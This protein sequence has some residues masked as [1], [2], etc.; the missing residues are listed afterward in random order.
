MNLFKRLSAL[1]T[2]TALFCT[3]SVSAFT[4]YAADDEEDDNIRV[5]NVFY[6]NDVHNAYEQTDSA[7]GYASL[8]ADI[9]LTEAEE[10]NDTVLVDAGDA[11]QGGIIGALSKGMWPAQIMEKMGYDVAVPGNHEFDFGLERFL[12][13]AD[14]VSYDYVSCNF[15]DLRTGKTVF[16]PYKM[17]KKFNTN[18]AFIGITT[19]E[20][21]GMSNPNY[22]KD[23]NGNDIY[24]FC[25]GDNGRE[26]YERVQQ[27]IDEAK[28]AG[29]DIVIAVG[30]T[31]I[32][33]SSSP[34][35]TGEIIANV[36]G[37]DAYIDGHSHSRI[38]GDNYTDKDGNKVT[39]TSTGTKF[40]NYGS[41]G[42]QECD[43][44]PTLNGI[45]YFYLTDRSLSKE[46][47]E[48]MLSF[49]N[50]ISDKVKDTSEKVVAKSEVDLCMNDPVTHKRLVRQQET[51]LGDFCADAYRAVMDADIALINGGG[52]R[53]DI[54]K[55]DVTVGDLIEA[56]PFGNL[57][58]TAQI[59]G[60]T[61]LDILE[62]SVEYGGD[63]TYEAGNFQ[64]VSGITFDVDTTIPSPVVTDE[65]KLFVRIDGKRRVNNVK[66]GGEP[67]DPEKI[68][69]VASHNYLLKNCG[70]GFTM[71][72][73]CKIVKD[74]TVLDY[75]ALIT[76]VT[77]H[78]G[79][80]I[81]KDSGYD[82][83]YGQSRIRLYNEKT[84][85]SC[86]E[87]GRITYLRGDGYITETSPA[88]GHSYGEWIT[89]TEATE[90]EEGLMKR[91]CSE[92]GKEEFRSLGTVPVVTDKPEDTN[93]PNE[94]VKPDE[95]IP[96]ESS[97]EPVNPPTGEPF[98][99]TAVI[100]TALSVITL[101]AA[102][103]KNR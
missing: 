31:G 30:H 6:T 47:D 99:M 3:V 83:C 100:I 5:I 66:V 87:E 15:I 50:G 7:V 49:I 88:K 62:M 92:C 96:G 14:S 29:A 85:P 63:L 56:H 65:N 94:T 42:I 61:V 72:R 101:A 22:F 77:D 80:V 38:V 23:E 103:R 21:Y 37:L 40:E 53:A 51:N 19:P 45:S 43:E 12:E 69:T 59:S 17:I 48:E 86:E 60:Q 75:E 91:V 39:V 95:V 93:K 73:D 10:N 8:A 68:Y 34:W 18:I 13:I 46:Q 89:V 102:K 26:L 67:I 24:G 81:S 74:E 71:L 9:K 52:L 82:D 98:A 11:L 4:A 16:M 57:L 20:A 35:T 41:L 70:G 36:S 1:L 25:G 78:L 28:N 2:A 84:E 27:T 55:G 64:H 58:C 54:S 90:T 97:G 79:G 33:P 32:D 76:Y 44:D